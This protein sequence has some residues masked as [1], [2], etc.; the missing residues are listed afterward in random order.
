MD[1]SCFCA[2]WDRDFKQLH[3]KVRHCQDRMSI[4]FFFF[5]LLSCNLFIISLKRNPFILK[6]C[7]FFKLKIIFSIKIIW[8]YLSYI[9]I[10]NLVY[11]NL[12]KSISKVEIYSYL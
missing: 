3:N 1:F 10:E 12:T 6:R 4:V 9:K 2:N 8:F 7:H 11:F 5:F